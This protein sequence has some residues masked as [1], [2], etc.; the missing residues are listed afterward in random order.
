[1][2]VI[3]SA[4]Q[5]QEERQR[6]HDAEQRGEANSVQITAAQ[7]QAAAGDPG[8]YGTDP[9]CESGAAPVVTVVNNGR[10]TITRIEAQ[11]S[12]ESALYRALGTQHFTSYA[13][14]PKELGGDIS[15]TLTDART[16]MLTPGNT[17]MRFIGGAMALRDLHGMYPD[18][19]MDGSVGNSLGAQSRSCP[20]DR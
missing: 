20:A 7:I 5:L 12:N 2:S 11:F 4:A 3:G 10:C 19:P 1:L 17:G 14:L 8:I 16:A 13:G 6:P 9:P 15:G 18:R